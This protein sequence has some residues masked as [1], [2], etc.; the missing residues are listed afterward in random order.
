MGISLRKEDGCYYISKGDLI[1]AKVYSGF[2]G[3][4]YY[5]MAAR[6]DPYIKGIVSRILY[7]LG[8]VA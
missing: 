8:G 4:I 3:V 1:L 2:G 6:D 5:S 7:K